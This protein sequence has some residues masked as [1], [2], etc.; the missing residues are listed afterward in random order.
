MQHHP[1][2]MSVKILCVIR[3]TTSFVNNLYDLIK[4]IFFKMGEKTTQIFFLLLIKRQN[5]VPNVRFKML[6]HVRYCVFVMNV[7]H[8]FYVHPTSLISF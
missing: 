3:I 4:N 2:H 7:V 1:P 6:T 8:Y 5:V